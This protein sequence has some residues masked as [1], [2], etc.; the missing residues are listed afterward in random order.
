MKF[1]W[2]VVFYMPVTRLYEM[3]YFGANPRRR[4]ITEKLLKV[5]D[6]GSKLFRA[7]VSMSWNSLANIEVTS[8]TG[9]EAYGPL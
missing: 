2:G 5:G 1:N 9:T 6:I 7:A 4:E 8:G 3:K